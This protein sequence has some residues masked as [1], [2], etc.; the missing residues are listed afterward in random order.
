M[1]IKFIPVKIENG[2]EVQQI[3]PF[4]RF[5]SEEECKLACDAL[6]KKYNSKAWDDDIFFKRKVEDIPTEL[7][8]KEVDGVSE[9]VGRK[10]FESQE[11]II[12]N[13]TTPRIPIDE[14][15]TK[16]SKLI[17]EHQ[18]EVDYKKYNIRE[19]T[20][21]IKGNDHSNA[22]RDFDD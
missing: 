9:E 11:P 8:Y 13:R 19:G 3:T 10:F 14:L 5:E 4:G 22:S 7:F 12:V 17:E 21:K 20:D 15:L 16:M 2:W 6:H 1:E 18:I